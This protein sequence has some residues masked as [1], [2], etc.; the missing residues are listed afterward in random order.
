MIR[1]VKI[2][3]NAANPQLPLTPAEVFEDSAVTFIIIGIPRAHGKQTI[4]GVSVG[5]I[6]P[7]GQATAIEAVRDGSAWIATMHAADIGG[8]G[9]VKNGILI[10]ASGKD[11]ND[12]PVEAWILGAG[13]LVV[14]QHDGTIKP[15]ERLNRVDW[16]ETAP[17]SPKIGNLA[18]LDGIIKIY[19]S[20]GW[21]SLG[22]FVTIDWANITGKP[23]TFPPEAHTHTKSEITD[24]PVPVIPSTEADDS[25]FASA[26]KVAEFVNSSINNLAAYYLTYTAQGDAFPTKAALDVATTFY[27]GGVAREPTKNDYLIVLADEEHTT[28]LGVNPTTR[29]VYDGAQWAF[30]YV[31]N[32]TSLTQAQVDA[33]NSGI[34]ALLVNWLSAFKGG[35]TSTTLASVL[36]ELNGKIDKTGGTATDLTVVEPLTIQASQGGN[37]AMFSVG[38]DDGVLY[39]SGP[40]DINLANSGR[41]LNQINDKLNELD[42]GK[43]NVS[44][45]RYPLYAVPSTGL[46]KDRAINTTNLASVTVP[47]DFTDLLVRASVATSLPVTMP[48]AITT[49]YGDTFPAAAGEYLITI[50]K[51]GAAEAYVRVIKL[52]V[53]Q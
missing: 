40:S 30:Q 10:S 42:D 16:F 6:N 36:S 41:T 1:T 29:Y 31:V 26:K 27:N 23:D 53:A 24:F 52:E 11:E 5:V 17:E 47:D 50:T 19:T 14:M 35:D 3:I 15:G 37:A 22:G 43:A 32:N 48:S 20:T 44:D 12:S 34:T 4:T 2:E 45:L 33:I 46:L 39:I 28:A 9:T 21:T 49:K 13:D 38:T 8:S 7:D 51:T 25:E 18:P